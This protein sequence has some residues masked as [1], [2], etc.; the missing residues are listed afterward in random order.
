M[1]TIKK[2]LHIIT[3]ILFSVILVSCDPSEG[4]SNNTT[5]SENFGSAATRNF[6][7]Q[8]VD[9]S[10]NP[11]PNANIKIGSSTT[12]TDANGIF[13]LNNASVYEK[14]AFIT[15]KK[16]GFIDG[17]R[18]L[19]P[20]TG[21]NNVRIMLLS[22]APTATVSTGVASEVTLLSG[23]KVNFDGSFQDENGIAYS[24][25]VTV[26]LNE[27]KPSNSNLS[28]IMPGSLYA[29]AANGTEKILQTFGMMNVELKGSSGQKLQ[30][31]TGHTAQITMDIDAASLATAPTTIPLW[32]FDETNG[33][34]IE[35]GTAT[36]TG[37]KYVGTVSHFS[38]WNCDYPNDKANLTI[39]VV[40]GSNDPISNV[41][42]GIQPAGFVYEASG[43]TNSSGVVTGIV[44]ANLA[45]PIKIYDSCNNV[46]F[47]TTISALSTNSSFTAP[48]VVLTSAIVGITNI[49]GNLVKCDNTNVTNG[50][51]ILHYGTFYS[52][53]PITN[54]AFN[55]TTTYCSPGSTAFTLEGFDYDNAQTTGVLNQTFS[56]ASTLV[57]NLS[58]CTA[59]TE[60]ITYQIDGGSVVNIYSGFGTTGQGS[61]YYIT[62]QNAIN[63]IYFSGN[64]GTVGTYTSSTIS[65]EG[66]NIGYISSTTTNTMVYHVNS[67][68]SVGQYI[69]ITF[70]GTY[71]DPASVTHTLVGSVHV[72]RQ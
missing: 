68:G 43:Y 56:S 18:T 29:E 20:T 62:G 2:N 58:A 60:F 46:V 57:G 23:T 72:I 27:L 47:T 40:D 22:S 14:F 4:S 44:P 6:I 39:T 16:T 3:L 52:A 69:D 35:D 59:I 64:F 42:V 32:H 70:N 24:G 33:Y 10:N 8:V 17:S 12:L 37:T 19:V 65:L 9:V 13:I 53:Q 71:V 45:L 61:F 7:G 25:T 5:F 49:T 11:I 66:T 30:I 1:K 48:T 55:F 50:Y 31:A 28:A 34:W 21:S 36:K 67:F 51:V 54:G 38:W 41:R 15:A 26:A 63:S